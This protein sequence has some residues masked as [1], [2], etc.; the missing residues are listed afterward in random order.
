MKD[1]YNKNCKSLKKEIKED[2]R[3]WKHIPCPWI[4]KINVIKMVTPLK[5]IYIF[6]AKSI[7]IPVI[8][9][10]EIEKSILKFIWKHKRFE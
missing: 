4:A 6:N 2:I 10:T 7:K 5:T 9:L 8:F 3:R 1:L